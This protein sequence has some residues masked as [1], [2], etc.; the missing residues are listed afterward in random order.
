MSWDATTRTITGAVG[1]GDI[2]SALNVSGPPYDLGTMIDSSST[3]NPMAIHKPIQHGSF[4]I[5]SDAQK[6]GVNYGLSIPELSALSDVFA[7]GASYA[8]KY[9]KPTGGNL[10]YRSLDFV[11]GDSPSTKGY[12]SDAPRNILCC[13]QNSTLN[14]NV[15]NEHTTPVALFYAFSKNGQG[16]QSPTSTNWLFDKRPSLSTGIGS[17]YGHTEVQLDCSIGIEDVYAGG[18]GGATALYGSN[19]RLG[20]AVKNGNNYSFLACGADLVNNS[21]NSNP[22]ML[23]VSSATL[24]TLGMGTYTAVGCLRVI[25]GS[26]TTYIPLHAYNWNGAESQK[27]TFQITTTGTGNYTVVPKGVSATASGSGS[28]S[29]SISGSE[30][31]YVATVKNTSSETHSTTSTTYDK[32][33]ISIHLTGSYTRRGST[34][35][36]DRWVTAKI[37]S[38][39]GTVVTS[40][41][42]FTIGS[43]ST[44]TMRFRL[45]NIWGATPDDYWT[46]GSVGYSSRAQQ[47]TDPVQLKFDGTNFTVGPGA[48]SI[49]ITYTP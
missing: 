36:V 42:S 21:G 33:Q 7:S 29:C 34:V 19:H 2:S 40:T 26:T 16:T 38:V 27:N 39:D 37:Y 49:T 13:L 15:V 3:L 9:L 18:V 1:F 44:V 23:K 41:K 10:P 30:V 32:W 5:L 4:G 48:D 12:Y 11:S 20:L 6:A 25:S 22:D 46:A 24:H 47:S 35:S 28:G 17:A 8:W 43:G 31:Y 45:D 14:I